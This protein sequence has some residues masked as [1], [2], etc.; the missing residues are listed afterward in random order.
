M[1]FDLPQ[2]LIVFSAGAFVLGWLLSAILSGIK[3]RRRATRR[4]PR[5]DRIR[6]L[7]A[8]LRVA[9]SD[10]GKSRKELERLEEE[11]KETTMGQTSPFQI[12]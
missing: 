5:D 7:Q 10:A 2:E 9:Q 3:A 1:F 8:E 11:L 6:A 4:D 12:M